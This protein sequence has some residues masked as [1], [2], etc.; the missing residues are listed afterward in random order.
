MLI[1]KPLCGVQNWAPKTSHIGVLSCVCNITEM[2][3]WSG[4]DTG[5]IG[6]DISTFQSVPAF[7]HP[8]PL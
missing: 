7:P 2:L 6:S 1:L 5:D 8:L 4:R 3:R